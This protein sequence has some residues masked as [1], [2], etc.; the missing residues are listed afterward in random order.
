MTLHDVTSLLAGLV[1]YWRAHLWVCRIPRCQVSF[2]LTTHS[3]IHLRSPHEPF[4]H[5]MSDTAFGNDDFNRQRQQDGA[6]EFMAARDQGGNNE[7]ARGRG[8][9]DDLSGTTGN[10]SMSGDTLRGQN[11]GGGAGYEH[12][13]DRDASQ[14]GMGGGVGAKGSGVAG[15]WEGGQG[16]GQNQQTQG[17]DLNQG[18]RDHQGKTR[19]F[20]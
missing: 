2:H 11:I 8:A 13:R 17:M 14:G 7:Y 19:G 20:L 4:T 18:Q 16:Q 5:T 6:G 10:A 12:V 1:I 9:G 15:G 3:R